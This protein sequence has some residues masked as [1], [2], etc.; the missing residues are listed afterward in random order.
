MRIALVYRSFHLTGSLS[1]RTVELARHLS[2]SHDV[3]VFSIGARTERSLAPDCTFHD[4]PVAH[5]GDGVRF[6]ARELLPF[7]SRAARLVDRERFDVVHVCNP[8][9]WV[10][11]VLNLPGVARGEAELQGISSVRFV[12]TALRHPGNAARR[13]IERRA[14]KNRALRRIHV[15]APSVLADLGRYHGIS[16]DRILVVRPAVNLAEFRPAGNVAGERASVA[17]HDPGRTVLLFCGSNFER[18]GLD[19]AIEALA[20]ADVDAELLVIG[21]CREER[22][23][24]ALAR[25]RGVGDFV[26]F[27]GSRPD[28]ARFYRAADILLLPTRADVWGITPIEAMASGIPSIVSS[29]AGSAAEVRNAGAGIV[30]SEPFD[31]RDLRD[32]VERLARDP[33]KRQ[34]MGRNGLVAAKAHSWTRRGQLIEN[35]LIDVAEKKLA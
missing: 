3:H 8:S 19:R 35:D 15:D 28:I 26:H 10:G 18:K 27:L 34:E 13:I 9:T 4:V 12:A 11:E 24:H 20:A 23:F 14:L 31:I 7:A 22:R 16:S 32:A 5:L 33:G 25:A 2:R 17:L 29:A 30:L 6:S 21:S 1:R